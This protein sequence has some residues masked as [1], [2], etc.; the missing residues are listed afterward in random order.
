MHDDYIIDS[1]AF[2]TSHTANG[3][4]TLPSALSTFGNT[5]LLI[6]RLIKDAGVITRTDLATLSGLTPARITIIIRELLASGLIKETSRIKGNQG[7]SMNGL[8]LSTDIFCTI[9]GRVTTHYFAIGLYDINSHCIDVKKT[10]FD[11]FSDIT[12]A[13]NAITN[14]IQVYLDMAKGLHLRPIA[15]ALGLMGNFHIT[16]TQCIMTDSQKTHN[17]DIRQYLIDTFQLPVYCGNENVLSLYFYSYIKGFNYFSNKTVI[18]V[19]ISYSIDAIIM[20]NRTILDGSG[21]VPGSAGKTIVFGIPPYNFKTLEQCISTQETI[22]LAKELAGKA[23]HSVLKD[24][25]N[26]TSRDLINAF[27]DND[28]VAVNVYH[29]VTDVLG[30]YLA[31]I[32]PLVRPHMILITDEIPFSDAYEHMLIDA[33]HKYLLLDPEPFPDISCIR[34]KKRLTSLDPAICGASMYATNAEMQNPSF[35]TIPES[36]Y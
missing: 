5:K 24:M 17:V 21:N 35:L 8:S 36:D 34:A 18:Y 12:A 4:S 1:T 28:P 26:I 29:Y 7:R 32:I 25:E 3:I 14:Q 6:L 13:L 10:Y 33:T 23:P 16:S 31:Q 11:V 20:H 22:N 2:N 30:H 27:W 15:I 19:S 9:A